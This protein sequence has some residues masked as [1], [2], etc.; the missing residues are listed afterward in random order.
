[1]S[2]DEQNVIH[3]NCNKLTSYSVACLGKNYCI[4]NKV[5]GYTKVILKSNSR[6]EPSY[7]MVERIETRNIMKE[8]K[9]YCTRNVIVT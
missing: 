1:M 7:C 4:K 2:V 8:G 5:M 9:V 6:S 3:D